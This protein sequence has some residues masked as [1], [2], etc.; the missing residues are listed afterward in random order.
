MYPFILIMVLH[1][2]SCLA[3]AV[4]II[5]LIIWAAKNLK[6][7][8]LKKLAV[9][10]IVIGIVGTLVSIGFGKMGMGYGHGKKMM[11]LKNGHKYMECMKDID[12][13]V[14]STTEEEHE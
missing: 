12:T 13:D 11:G 9:I 6:K 5:L 4:G 7:K 2:L 3:L 10:L 8:D 1:K 14:D